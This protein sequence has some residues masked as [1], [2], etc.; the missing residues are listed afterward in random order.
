VFKL[1]ET[2]TGSVFATVRAL[3]GNEVE[4]RHGVEGEY[5]MP[6]SCQEARKLAVAL[7]LAAEE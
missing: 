3:D 2:V 7:L 6:L 5:G 4:I 1:R